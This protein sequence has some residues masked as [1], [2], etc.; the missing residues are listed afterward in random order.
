MGISLK[1][2]FLANTLSQVFVTALAIL[3]VP[4]YLRWLG[5][6]AYGLVGLFATLQAWFNLL[7]MGLTPTLA[8]E[9]SRFHAGAMSAQ[10]FR[11]LFRGMGLVF[12]GL[13]VLG[14]ILLW[15]LAPW[16]E[17]HWLQRQSLLA[18]EVLWALRAMAM[19]VV[20]R[21]VAGLYRG[22]LT[23]T[24][25]QVG[26]AAVTVVMA[27]VR[28]LGVLA[29]MAYWGATV[30]VFFDFQLFAAL[31]ETLVLV[32]WTHAV[33]P[34]A[35]NPLAWSLR[36][37][38]PVLGMGLSLAFASSVWVLVNQADKLL[39]SGLL[40]LADYG[41]FSLAVVLASGVM[42]LS[43]ALSQA[44]MP[45]LAVL[46]AKGQSVEMMA[47]YRR[48]T[49]WMSAMGLGGALT[50]AVLA[51]PVLLA[52]TGQHAIA[53]K[54]SGVLALYA[55]GYGFACLAAFPYY[56]QYALGQMRLHVWGNALMLLVLVPSVWL[57]APIWGGLGTAI[58]W[59]ILNFCFGAF[60][61]GVVHRRYWPGQHL[62][63]LWRDITLSSA[64]ALLGA[65][66]L[67]LWLPLPQSRWGALAWAV[68]AGG[69]LLGLNVLVLRWRER[70]EE[71]A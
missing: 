46:H 60:W 42:V 38:R 30:Q 7:D 27:C 64:P 34:A 26:L 25:R 20:L 61:G 32:I 16:A 57:V 2:T 3:L 23:G 53:G 39:L 21:W 8:R 29:A 19:A 69:T 66:A 31:L 52:W 68:F 13:A 33:L 63:W 43:G 59:L 9:S 55:L 51:E 48:S 45:R 40:P 49:R 50:L 17:A 41:L 12:G 11:Q 67:W 58:V 44:L 54:M 36:S 6:E 18:D 47:L 35:P 71:L 28:Y 22:F 70:T 10:A 65:I 24:D 1:A 37:V 14:A 56:L 15:S 5:A 62:R 4:V